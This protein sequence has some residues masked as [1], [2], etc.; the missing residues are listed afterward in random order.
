[1]S[2]FSQ[3]FPIGCS[4]SGGGGGTIVV[5]SDT[6][7]APLPSASLAPA[8]VYEW[9]GGFYQNTS[10]FKE[11]TFDT[12][13]SAQPLTNATGTIPAAAYTIVDLDN[14]DFPNGGALLQTTCYYKV[15]QISNQSWNLNLPEVI[16][17]IDGVATSYKRANWFRSGTGGGSISF[18]IGAQPFDITAVKDNGNNST[19]Y[20]VTWSTINSRPI[21][22]RGVDLGPNKNLVVYDDLDDQL[23]S[24]LENTYMSPRPIA[25]NQWMGYGLPWLRWTTDLKIELAHNSYN[26]TNTGARLTAVGNVKH[27]GL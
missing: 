8:S 24:G 1:M 14:T 23:Y 27:M 19:N 10:N 22:T 17:T 16:I 11:Y 9:N 15:Q 20:A 3:Y 7:P 26:P 12:Q 18:V 13:Y 5:G 21:G 6:Y 25:S 4:S 2:N